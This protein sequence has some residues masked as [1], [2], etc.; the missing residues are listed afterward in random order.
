MAT[1]GYARVSSSDQSTDTQVQRLKAAGC[2]V[3]RTE[4][5]SGKSREGRDQLATLLEFIG[6]GDVL[7]CVKLDRLGRSTRDVLNLVHE[8]D[9]KG[10]F[11]RILEPAISTDGP[12]GKMVLTVLGMVAEM[13]LGFIKARQRDGI[14]QAKSKGDVYKGRKPTID[15]LAVRD[16]FNEG[17]GA[18]EIA[19]R[20]KIGRASVYRVLE[21]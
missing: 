20:L 2:K 5:I 19:R 17:I 7:V 13:E 9:Q 16:L 3:V 15:R 10:A 21:L 18:S 14:E 6:P 8:L 11:L 4:K 12:M 1:Y